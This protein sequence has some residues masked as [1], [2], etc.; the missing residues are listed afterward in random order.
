MSQLVCVRREE[1]GTKLALKGSEH[2]L[3]PYKRG[4]H[5]PA[6]GRVL[7][8]RVSSPSKLP[9]VSKNSARKLKP[10]G[11]LRTKDWTVNWRLKQC[12]WTGDIGK[13][14][15]RAREVSCS[16]PSTHIF[17]NASGGQAGSAD[18]K[19]EQFFSNRLLSQIQ[20]SLTVTE[21]YYPIGGQC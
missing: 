1:Q 8:T 5:L 18:Q 16:S 9:L 20:P 17:S 10:S 14:I 15:W 7:K 11:I 19:G 12:M 13:H 3:T 4:N 6:S 21:S 2:L